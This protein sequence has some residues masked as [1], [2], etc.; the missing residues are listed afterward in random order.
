M[1][2]GRGRIGNIPGFGRRGFGSVARFFD[3]IA[4]PDVSQETTENPG[5]FR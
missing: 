1:L 5:I 3:A 4:P 2:V